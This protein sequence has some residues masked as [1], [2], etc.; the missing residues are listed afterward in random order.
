MVLSFLHG[1]P[2]VTI[3]LILLEL[4]AKYVLTCHG[5]FNSGFL[6]QWVLVLASTPLL[7]KFKSHTRECWLDAVVVRTE[8]A[9]NGR[10]N[11]EVVGS[12]PTEVKRF[13]LYQVSQV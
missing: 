3:S 8:Q 13:F 9:S 11:P 5:K 1:L 6:D 12:I 7:T 2:W 10:S 4:F